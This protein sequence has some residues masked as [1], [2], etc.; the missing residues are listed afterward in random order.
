MEDREIWE[1][2]EGYQQ[3]YQVSN[4]GNIKNIKT[5]KILKPQKGYKGYMKVVLCTEQGYKQV[6]VHRL[7]ALYHIPNPNNYPSINHID[8]NKTNNRV[9]NLEWCTVSHNNRE[10]YRLGLKQSRIKPKKVIKLDKNNNILKIYKSLNSV[11]E[12]GY[13][14]GNVGEVC[15]GH[16][17]KA[18]GYIWRYLDEQNNCYRF[19]K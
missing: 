13:N 3:K 18:G 12:D 16:R 19:V 14:V 4:L 8:G 10:A 2:I 9:E 17:K 15:A 6:R 7:V 1:D 5:N 11:K